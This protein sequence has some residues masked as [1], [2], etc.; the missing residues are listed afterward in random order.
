MD[1][2]RFE[3][4]VAEVGQDD[5]H[6]AALPAVESGVGKVA[7]RGVQLGQFAGVGPHAGDFFAQGILYVA[8]DAHVRHHEQCVVLQFQPFG[9]VNES[10]VHREAVCV[11]VGGA[12]H[13]LQVAD[14]GGSDDGDVLALVPVVVVVCPDIW[15]RVRSNDKRELVVAVAGGH[16]VAVCLHVRCGS[17]D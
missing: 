4:V 2:G 13:P 8:E 15:Q 17:R 11:V 3:V 7:Q 12:L 1:D 9:D 16:H 5:L 6:G 14:D 10:G